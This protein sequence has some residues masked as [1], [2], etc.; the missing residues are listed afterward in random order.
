MINKHLFKIFIHNALPSKN[1]KWIIYRFADCFDNWYIYMSI[2]S[3]F[4]PL[5]PSG[6]D[7]MI[8]FWRYKQNIMK[9]VRLNGSMFNKYGLKSLKVML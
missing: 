5:L 3:V 4:I 1:L 9:R 2:C 7:E 8:M 6:R